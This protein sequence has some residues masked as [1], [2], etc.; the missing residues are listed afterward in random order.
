[1]RTSNAK[2]LSASSECVGLLD[3]VVFLPG[4]ELPT[5]EETR[6]KVDLALEGV[7]VEI[8]SEGGCRHRYTRPGVLMARRSEKW[9]ITPSCRR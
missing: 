6:G 5:D 3:G 8:V 2:R 7:R 1:M 4:R 9:A